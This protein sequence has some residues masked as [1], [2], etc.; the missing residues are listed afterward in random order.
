MAGGSWE[1]MALEDTKEPNTQQRLLS[2]ISHLFEVHEGF[3]SDLASLGV[4]QASIH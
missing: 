3:V 2:P 1:W 4:L